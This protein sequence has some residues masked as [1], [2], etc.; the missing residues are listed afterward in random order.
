MVPYNWGFQER[1]EFILTFNLRP[2]IYLCRSI[3]VIKHYYGLKGKFK[4]FMT[5]NIYHFFHQLCEHQDLKKID[6]LK[7]QFSVNFII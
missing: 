6:F 2:F 4:I 7:D 1:I 3:A 5:Q